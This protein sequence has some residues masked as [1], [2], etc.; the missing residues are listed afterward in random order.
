MEFCREQ[1]NAPKQNLRARICAQDLWICSDSVFNKTVP[2]FSPFGP[3][4]RKKQPAV[5]SSAAASGDS[6]VRQE[7]TC[8]KRFNRGLSDGSSEAQVF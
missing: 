2:T 8:Y 3:K 5:Q 7:S 4:A 6:L 1:E